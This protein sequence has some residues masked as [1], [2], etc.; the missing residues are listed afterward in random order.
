MY[1]DDLKNVQIAGFLTITGGTQLTNGLQVNAGGGNITYDVNNSIQ[2]S[3][4]G[5]VITGS[6]TCTGG[7]IFNGTVSGT[8]ITT[9]MNN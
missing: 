2:V 3:Q 5:T 6:L 1:L 9:L 7:S 8:A 4:L